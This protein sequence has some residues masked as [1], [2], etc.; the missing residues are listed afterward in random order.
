[1]FNGSVNYV[2]DVKGNGLTF[3]RFEFDPKVPNV[4]K[5]ELEATGQVVRGTVYLTNVSTQEDGRR[6]A[7]KVVT[8]ALNRIS[9]HHASALELPFTTGDQF[10]AVH[11]APETLGSVGATV[12][13]HMTGTV[14]VVLGVN[15]T[16]LKN[17]LEE[18]ASPGEHNF[19]LFSAALRSKSPVEAFMH[20]YNILL[21]LLGD[22]QANVEAFVRTHEPGVP[23]TPHP[24]YPNSQ[25]PRMETVYT[26]LRNELGH[27]RAGVSLIHTKAEMENRVGGLRDLTKKAIEL[28]P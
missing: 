3:P 25:P 5:V 17:R 16:Q 27:Q 28:H 15:P 9:Y 20:L 6:I 10:A 18:A 23:E 22:N 7:L 19:E 24:L 4:E 2:T 21:M 8:D 13:L 26:R 1:M 12:V 11:P 14:G